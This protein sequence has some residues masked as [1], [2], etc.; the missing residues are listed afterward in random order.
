MNPGDVVYLKSG[1]PALT[2]KSV[3]GA[4]VEVTWLDGFETPCTAEFPVVCL[5]TTDPRGWTRK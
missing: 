2:I 5:T 3:R 1:S 4:N